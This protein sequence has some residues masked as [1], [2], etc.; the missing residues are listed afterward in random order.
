M[1]AFRGRQPDAA[2]QIGEM[3]VHLLLCR[4]EVAPPQ[5]GDDVTVIAAIVSRL[6]FVDGIH[7]RNARQDLDEDFCQQ[8][9]LAEFGK[10]DVE[11]RSVA[12]SCPI[13]GV[14]RKL[15]LLLV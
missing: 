5:C 12:R 6:D 3:P 2:F 4:S 14:F 9:V 7:K 10:L 8:V 13:A 15:G 1:V 11:L